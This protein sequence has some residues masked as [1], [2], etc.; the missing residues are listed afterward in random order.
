MSSATLPFILLQGL[1]QCAVTTRRS[2]SYTVP[3]QTQLD[4]YP[5]YSHHACSPQGPDQGPLGLR[6]VWISPS[7]SLAAYCLG[8]GLPEYSGW[9]SG[10][11]GSP[12]EI[13]PEIWKAPDTSNGPMPTAEISQRSLCWALPFP[14]LG[15]F[16]CLDQTK[17]SDLLGCFEGT[18]AKT[19][20]CL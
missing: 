7:Q 13:S 18:V 17:A 1:H 16:G 6:F 5:S 14:S 8:Y 15:L 9:F 11:W 2:K 20:V 19:Q 4:P 10:S 12:N 3:R